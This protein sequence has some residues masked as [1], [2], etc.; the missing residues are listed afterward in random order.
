MIIRSAAYSRLTAV[1]HGFSMSLRNPS[2]W[3][4][5]NLLTRRSHIRFIQMD[6]SCFGFG[7]LVSVAGSQSVVFSRYHYT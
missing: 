1:S 7:R 5:D 6:S 2:S 4:S 3:R